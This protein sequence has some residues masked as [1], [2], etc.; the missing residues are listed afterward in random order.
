PVCDREDRR[1][2][3]EDQL[4]TRRNVRYESLEPRAT[5][6]LRRIGRQSAGA[7]EVY[8]LASGLADRV[9]EQALP[10]DDLG[11]AGSALLPQVA[12]KA[13]A[14]EVAVDEEHALATRSQDIGQIHGQEGLPD[15][16]ARA[17]D[18]DDVVR[19]LQEGE[20]E[21]RPQAP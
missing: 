18:S 20:L 21:R 1:R 12:M 5:D 15:A 9:R 8:V 2:I 17:A 6:E 19:G 14:P 10:A 16:R 7:D 4:V 3:D 11:D 13:S